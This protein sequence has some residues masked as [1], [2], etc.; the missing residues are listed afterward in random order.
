MNPITELS[1][2]TSVLYFLQSSKKDV[3]KYQFEECA[4]QGIVKER[5]EV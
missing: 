1:S 3:W 2:L 5:E 4:I